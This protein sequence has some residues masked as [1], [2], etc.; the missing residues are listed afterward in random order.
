MKKDYVKPA[1]ELTPVKMEYTLC[2]TSL[3]RLL[4]ERGA[5][6]DDSD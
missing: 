6:D 2:L 1:A 4:L 3:E 5:F